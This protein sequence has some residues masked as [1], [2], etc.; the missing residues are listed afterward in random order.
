LPPWSLRVEARGFAAARLDRVRPGAPVDVRLAKGGVITGTVRDAAD[1]KPLRGAL[2]RAQASDAWRYS[3]ASD[4]SVG[5]IEA[6][7]DEAGRY[8]VEGLGIGLYTV[9]A[10]APRFGRAARERVKPGATVDFVLMPGAS[11]AGSVTGRDGK[12]VTDAVVRAVPEGDFEGAAPAERTDRSGSFLIAGLPP[13]AYRLVVT[14]PDFALGFSSSVT[15]ERLQDAWVGVTLTRGAP[16]SGRLQGASGRPIAG[17]VHVQEREG[18]VLP[19]EA[20]ELLRA[21]A[22]ADGRFAL[23]RLSTGVWA[24][25]VAARGH[26]RQRVELEVGRGE[27]PLDLGDIAL[28]VGTSIRGRVQDRAGRAVAGATISGWPMD[29][30]G[31]YVPSEETESEADG[32]FALGG[33]EAGRYSL[34]ASAPGFA[35][36]R[37]TADAGAEDVAMVLDPGGSITGLVVDD[38]GRA[39][40]AYRVTAERQAGRNPERAYR[41]VASSEGRFD[42]DDLAE[43]VYT[44]RV[45]APDAAPATSSGVRVR[46]GQTTDAGRIRLGRGGVVRGVVVTSN[47]EPVPAAAVRANTAGSRRGRWSETQSDLSGAFELRGVPPGRVAVWAWHPSYAPSQPTYLDVDPKGGPAEARL[48]LSEGGRIQ[49]SARKRDGTPLG[50][51]LVEIYEAGGAFGF[52]VGLPRAPVSAD[53]TFVFEHVRPGR[54]DLML[55]HETRPGSLESFQSTPVNVAEGQTTLA[56]LV[57]R[58]VL[59]SGRVTRSDVPLPNARIDLQQQSSVGSASS[60]YGSN[61][62]VLAPRAGPLPFTA[63]TAE[64]GSFELI[65]EPGSVWLT[66]TSLDRRTSYADRTVDIPDADSFFLELKLGGASV[67]GIVVDESSGGPIDNAYVGAAPEKG[68]LYGGG[69]TGPDGRFAFDVDPGHYRLSARAKDYA[70]SQSDLDVG[71][72]GVS[73]L[74]IELSRGGSIE[75][76]VVDSSGRPVAD[77]TVLALLAAAPQPAVERTRNQ[78]D[79]TFRLNGLREGAYNLATGVEA[80][81]FAIRPQVTPGGDAV[82]MTLRPGGRVRVRAVDESGAPVAGAYPFVRSVSGVRVR[83]PPTGTPETDERGESELPCPAGEVEIE[84]ANEKGSGTAS[85]KVTPGA[86]VLLPIL[87]RKAE[88]SS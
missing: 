64:D 73:D 58:E 59:V 12:P 17:R 42:F 48:V 26:A 56:E 72:G 55:M 51:L 83:L 6:K 79:G 47:D 87:L 20:A 54:Y 86:T 15:V 57:S 78:S 24:I 66:L 7:T 52:G 14:H 11:L 38:A 75:G 18:H 50:G 2:V 39:V 19:A 65:A 82:V 32:G 69:S 34:A 10:C 40:E 68:D 49:G 33:L 63:T 3:M 44:L 76:K 8:R 27:E 88:A 23:P 53:G 84:V 22:G 28:E 45:E 1:G 13:G 61:E 9:S 4:P 71:A 46:A 36:A 30:S 67:S 16:V 81:G 62:P 41:E 37:R 77:L 21:E 74:R 60:Y 80:I 31:V 85:A 43:D 35:S 5:S 25:A 29:S 70:P